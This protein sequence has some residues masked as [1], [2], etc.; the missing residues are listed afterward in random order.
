MVTVT[1]QPTS[2]PLRYTK[3]LITDKLNDK[4]YGNLHIF[5]NSVKFIAGVLK[6]TAISPDDVKI[7]CAN[8]KE[9]ERKLLGYKIGKP[10]DAP[11]KVNFY[12]STCFEG[13]DIYDEEGKTYIISE[14][15]NP[16]TLYDISTLFIQII[17][18][19][20]NSKYRDNIFH[21]VSNTQ[22]NGTVSYQDFKTIVEKEYEISIMAANGYNAH[23]K[24]LRKQ[25]YDK[26]GEAHFMNRFLYVNKD[27]NFEI[28]RNLLNKNLID[29]KLKT[30]VYNRSYSLI[31]AY[32]ENGLNAQCLT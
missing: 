9:N 7:V 16:H 11:C 13:C 22:Y 30:E 1:E 3:D 23:E 6:R 17:G 24:H 31:E 20:R 14:G 10:S 25:I 27:Y 2:S 32:R 18:R 12:T 19:I 29:Y 8:S 21:V 26:W 28:D 4:V 15:R 5:V